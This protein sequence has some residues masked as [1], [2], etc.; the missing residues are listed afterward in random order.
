MSKIFSVLTLVF[1][2]NAF[3]FQCPDLVRSADTGKISDG[4]GNVSEQRL[5]KLKARGCDISAVDQ[6]LADY[7]AE[8]RAKAVEAAEKK[9]AKYKRQRNLK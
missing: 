6:S 1:S 3:A 7:E 8:I 4:I 5:A 9:I 2:L